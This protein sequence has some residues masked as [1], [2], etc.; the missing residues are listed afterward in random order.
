MKNL[1]KSA[2]LASMTLLALNACTMDKEKLLSDLV[3]NWKSSESISG[4][5]YDVARQFYPSKDG[6]SGNFIEDQTHY[7]EEEDAHGL[8]F[9]L[10][11]EILMSG[12]YKVNDFG[13][14][15]L[16]YDTASLALI[17]DE[18]DMAAYQHRV[19][20][21]DA[22]RDNPE[23]TDTSTEDLEEYLQYLFEFDHYVV[24]QKIY[25][26]ISDKDGEA[27]MKG[28]KIEDDK[29]SFESDSGK[30]KTWTKIEDFFKEDFFDEKAEDAE[31]EDGK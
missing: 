11:Y 29:L 10:H 31:G 8:P 2:F 7:V 12:T 28:V 16:Q 15:S 17:P 23:Y 27:S 21:W 6:E 30:S 3:G 20:E 4:E 5:M 9:N 26:D 24:W 19:R 13:D 25:A 14:I 18:D 22:K 1:M